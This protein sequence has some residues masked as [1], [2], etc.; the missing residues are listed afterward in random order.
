MDGIALAKAIR[1]VPTARSLALV[2]LSSIGQT[3]P[4]ESAEAGF[5]AV[6]SKPVKLSTLQDRLCEI[7]G[8]R[9]GVMPPPDPAPKASSRDPLRILVAED[10]P[11]NQQVALRLLER[12]GHH[13]ELAASGREVLEQL[14]RSDYDV[15][16]MDVQMP[17]MDG[18]ETT[19]AICAR[20][21]AGERPRII[22]MT[23]EA[24]EGDREACLAAG[25]DDYVV[26]PVRL[27]RLGRA[28][29]QC[30]QV[31]SRGGAAEPSAPGSA[32]S[33]ALDHRVL[34]EL[35]ADLGGAEELRQVIVTFLDGTPRFLAAL[36]DAAARNDASGMRQAAHALKSSSAML[37]AIAL[38]TQCGELEQFSRSGTVVDAVAR[39][40]VIEDLYRAVALAF[41][42]DAESLAADAR[43]SRSLS[44]GP[45]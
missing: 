3:L 23:A 32:S 39:V 18:L 10:N 19:R 21:P 28:L 8:R 29:A 26:K 35:Q 14:S 43:A 6:L 16:L 27:D 5:A 30:R 25:M 15:I 11:A 20:W 4:V 45:T 13:A 12:L 17:E 2:L 40:A 22:A 42:A 34:R 9:P 44:G 41:E 37:G 31:T 36:R 38:S 1:Q 33:A 24:M 7:L